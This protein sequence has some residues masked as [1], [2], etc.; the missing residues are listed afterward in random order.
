MTVLIDYFNS[1]NVLVVVIV[2]VVVVVV[3]LNVVIVVV[4]VVFVVNC[5]LFL[6]SQRHVEVTTSACTLSLEVRWTTFPWT[7]LPKTMPSHVQVHGLCVS[8]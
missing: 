8:L 2:L 7:D 1:V 5:S 3:I 6:V 4:V